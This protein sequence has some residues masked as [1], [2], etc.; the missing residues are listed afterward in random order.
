[1]KENEKKYNEDI[2]QKKR[3]KTEKQIRKIKEMGVGAKSPKLIKHVW[4]QLCDPTHVTF[5]LILNSNKQFEIML[6]RRSD[7][8]R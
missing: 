8:K 3:R 5:V 4:D 6:R 1:M 2:R 7:K